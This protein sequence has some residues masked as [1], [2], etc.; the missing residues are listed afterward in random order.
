MRTIQT[1]RSLKFANNIVIL[2]AT[3]ILPGSVLA[4]PDG[5]ATPEQQQQ[6]QNMMDTVVIKPTHT[7]RR[8]VPP[9]D[10]TNPPKPMLLSNDQVEPGS[11]GLSDTDVLPDDQIFPSSE[12]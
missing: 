2:L 9:Y 5:A 6:E 8:L 11:D 10:P 1:A 12:E 4:A 3:L 7:G